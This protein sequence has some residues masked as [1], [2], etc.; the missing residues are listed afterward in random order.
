MVTIVILIFGEISPKS[1]AKEFPE[2]FAMFS[3][4]FLRLLMA[5]LLSLIHI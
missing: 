1:M 5:L 4:P 3:A 2:Q